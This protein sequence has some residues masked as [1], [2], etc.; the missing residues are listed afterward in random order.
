MKF[1]TL[2][3]IIYSVLSS[4]TLGLFYGCIYSASEVISS[5]V[6]KLI[7]SV[8]NVYLKADGFTKA[9]VKEIISDKPETKLTRFSENLTDAVIFTVFGIGALLLIYITL[10]GV[11]R[12]Y[13]VVA[14]VTA[15][16]LARK[17]L[18]KLFCALFE[19]IFQILYTGIVCVEYLLLY[20]VRLFVN[21]IK[22]TLGRIMRP[23]ERKIIKKRSLLLSQKKILEIKKIIS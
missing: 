23:I 8:P 6:H 2:Q 20:P 13:V 19:R 11:F 10:D 17:T 21:F 22:E 12:I 1:F 4:F 7:F 16:I 14:L 18:G 5:S 3:E 9:K 15:F